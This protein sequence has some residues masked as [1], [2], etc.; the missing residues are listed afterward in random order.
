MTKADQP[1]RPV[2]TIRSGPV[3]LAIWENETDKGKRY[4]VTAQRLYRDERGDWQTTG[5]FNTADLAH[6]AFAAQRAEIWIHDQ[7]EDGDV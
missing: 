7:Q 4:N 3:K 6:L 5:G 2:K 1:K